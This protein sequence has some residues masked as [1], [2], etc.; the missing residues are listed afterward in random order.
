MGFGQDALY[1]FELD[2]GVQDVEAFAEDIVYAAEDGVAFGRGHVVDEDVAAQG[3]GVGTEA[4]DVEVVDVDYAFDLA[5][6]GG[7]FFEL[8]AFGE[9]F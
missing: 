1:V 5:E 3:A 6:F 4:P 8:E 9:T 7:D 2:G